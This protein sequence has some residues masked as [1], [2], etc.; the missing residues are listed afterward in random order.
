ML[1]FVAFE[2]AGKISIEFENIN[3]L[4]DEFDWHLFPMEIQRRLP[5]I[6][7]N[8]QQPVGFRCFGSFLSNRDTFKKVSLRVGGKETKYCWFVIH[9]NVFLLLR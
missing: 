7:A 2:L 9:I 6:I 1:L 3:D 5:M 4:I 8:V